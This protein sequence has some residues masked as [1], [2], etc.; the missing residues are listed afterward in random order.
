[1]GSHHRDLSLPDLLAQ[2][3]NLQQ[4]LKDL[5]REVGREE[6]HVT[7]LEVNTISL[8][9]QCVAIMLILS[10]V[11]QEGP[12]EGGQATSGCQQHLQGATGVGGQGEVPRWGH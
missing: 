4:E 6:N 7:H 2:V 12:G 3:D 8:L 10:G 1:M 11:D 9:C 5:G